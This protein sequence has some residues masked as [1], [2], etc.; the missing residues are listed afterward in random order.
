MLSVLPHPRSP[1]RRLFPYAVTLT[2]LTGVFGAVFAWRMGRDS[3]HAAY[4][5]PPTPVA[6]MVIRPETLPQSVE[7]IGALQAVRQVTLAPEV[8]GRVVEIHFEAGM[9]VAEGTPLVQ[10]Y[11]APQ[12]ADRAA[13]VSRNRFAEL[14]SSRSRGL[15]PSGFVSQ[16]VLQQREEELNQAKAAIA[17]LD[18]QI[19]QR[20][21]RAPFAGEIGLRRVN[22][23]QYVNAGDALATLTALDTLYVNFSV[24]QQELSRLHVGGAVA[25]RTDAYPDRTFD[26]KINAIEPVVAADTRNVAVQATFANPDR[27][28]RPGLYVTADVELAPRTDAIVVPATAIQTGASGESALLVRDGKAVAVPIVTGQRVGERIVVERGLKAG[29]TIVTAGQLRVQ[30]GGAVQVADAAPAAQSAR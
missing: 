10:L 8:A 22:L 18:A 13:A 27:L 28:L 23:G 30:P 12:R 5:R 24:P 25:V 17:Q 14:Q 19:A 1:L 15:A 21:I 16:E 26:A 2:L 20:V 3:G 6:A 9:T 7:A 11:D 29:D 4:A